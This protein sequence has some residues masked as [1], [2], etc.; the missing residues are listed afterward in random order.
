MEVPSLFRV[1][2]KDRGQVTIP[3]K[4]RKNLMLRSG[5][6][7]EIEIRGGCIILKPLQVVEREAERPEGSPEGPGG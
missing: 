3:A 4:I 7:L 2:V 5:D 6:L 1:T